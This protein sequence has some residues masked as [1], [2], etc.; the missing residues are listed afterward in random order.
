M[1]RVQF[2][3][4]GGKEVLFLNFAGCKTE[5][6]LSIIEEGKQVIRSRPAGSVLTLTDVTGTR[7]DDSVSDQMKEF[8]AHNKPYVKAAAVIGITGIKKII[9]DAVTI[10][11][12][13]KLQTFETLDLAKEWLI[14][15]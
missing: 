11:S 4:Y 15:H 12:K 3:T 9:F 7:F 13:R 14:S 6:I 8:A 5:E 10:F 1:G 2:I